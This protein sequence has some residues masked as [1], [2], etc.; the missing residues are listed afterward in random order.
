[1]SRSRKKVPYCGHTTA[2]SEKKD[3][4]IWHGQLRAAERTNLASARPEELENHVTAIPN[5]VM[6]EY[7]MAKDGKQ[8][9]GHDARRVMAHATVDRQIRTARRI[10]RKESVRI[11]MRRKKIVTRLL[12]RWSAK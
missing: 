3:K 9:W 8:Y 10:D 5:D 4:Q 1:M 11:E 7:D 6:N 2:R 12:H